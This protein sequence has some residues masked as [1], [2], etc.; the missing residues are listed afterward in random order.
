MSRAVLRAYQLAMKQGIRAK[1]AAGAQCVMGLTA[2]GS[3]KTVTMASTAADLLAEGAVVVVQAHRAELVGQLS[4]ALAREGIRHNLICSTKVRKQIVD[5]HLDELGRSFFD[6]AARCYVESVDTALKR[7]PHPGVTHVF[8]DEGHH[9]LIANKWGRALLKYPDAKYLLMTATSNRADG[10]GV[11]RV[12]AGLVDALEV[13]PGLA[14]LMAMGMLTT[15]QILH[16]KASDLDMSGVEIGANGE[17]N[18]QQ[19]A[20]AVHK[21]KKIVGDAVR[22]YLQHAAGKLCI[23]F[24]VDIE[25]AREL[26]ERYCAAGVRAELVTGEDLDDVRLGAMKRF[27]ARETT[28][29]VNVDLFGE[30]TDVPGVEVVQMCRPTASFALFCQMIGRMLRLNI[31]PFLMQQWDSISVPDRLAYIAAS[32]KPHALL[33]D[34]VGNIDT[35]FKVGDVE[36]SG[37]PEGFTG[38]NIEGRTRSRNT[39]SGIP[40]RTCLKCFQAYERHWLECPYCG[41]AAPEPAARGGPEEVDFD[42]RWYDPNL[43]AELRAKVQWIDGPAKLP[44]GLSAEAQRAAHHNW[45]ARQAAQHHLRAAIAHWA[46]VEGHDNDT[47]NYRKFGL[48][49]GIGVPH[50]LV[51]GATEADKLRERIDQKC[52]RQSRLGPSAGALVLPQLPTLPTV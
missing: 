39:G 34:H 10:K 31:A 4:L 17:L 14:E 11:A 24:A 3:G 20:R 33:I 46:G 49:F 2:T 29:L 50:A 23:V 26:T 1:W 41:E 18:Q 48:T 9:V 43:L 22:H 47:V 30:G 12:C 7:S 28:V 37:P 13:G 44:S 45:N 5:A 8:T 27:K 21:S 16:A 42:L 52:N 36:Y 6:P 40:Q 35:T 51:L 38:W 32:D 15:Y 25:H 19:S